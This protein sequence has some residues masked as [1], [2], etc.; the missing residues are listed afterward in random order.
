M[1]NRLILVFAL[2]LLLPL[3]SAAPPVTTVAQFAEGYVIEDTPQ[4]YL[5]TA[6]D[7]QYNF[8]VY[9]ISNGKMIDN[10]STSCVYYIANS[11]GSVLTYNTVP[12]FEDDMHWG[13]LIKGGNFTSEGAYFHGTSCQGTSLGGFQVGTYEVT[14]TGVELTE[15]RAIVYI[16]L[17]ALIVLIILALPFIINMLPA[18]NA[19]D[20]EGNLIQINWL[21]YLRPA[22]WFVEWILALSLVFLASNL[23][24]AYLVEETFANYLFTIFRIGMGI[25]PILAILM[26]VWS[27]V[28]YVS[29]RNIQKLMNR[30]FGSNGY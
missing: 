1:A 22:L 10:S 21:K 15:A 18:E 11:S 7:Y 8:F 25:T 28:K 2:L 13:I 27:A 16:G 29:D 30:G 17:L 3:L 5:K 23:A 14:T 20:Q 9:N 4:T 6:Q 24:F 12:Y 19:K 26:F